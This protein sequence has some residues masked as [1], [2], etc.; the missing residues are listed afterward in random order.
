[1]FV[2]F[3][4]LFLTPRSL[5]NNEC[6]GGMGSAILYIL[7][8]TGNQYSILGLDFISF[9]P[10]PPTQPIMATTVSLTP[11]YPKYISPC[12]LLCLIPPSIYTSV[13]LLSCVNEVTRNGCNNSCKLQT[14]QIFI[15]I[16]LSLS[17]YRKKILPHISFYIS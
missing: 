7:L 1:L 15:Y 16:S 6:E 10:S 4:L 11:A 17:L 2:S 13:R 3:F 9:T 12:P 5:Y 14:K 8:V